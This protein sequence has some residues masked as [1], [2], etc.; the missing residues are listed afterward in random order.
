MA[1]KLLCWEIIQQTT[2]SK[3]F[4]KSVAI[5]TIPTGQLTII[6]VVLKLKNISIHPWM[7]ALNPSFV[8]FYFLREK[9][10]ETEEVEEGD[11]GY[12]FL[13]LPR[14]ISTVIFLFYPT[15][16]QAM[17]G[18]A[19]LCATQWNQD[20]HRQTCPTTHQG[21]RVCWT[22]LHAQQ[23]QALG[24]DF[25]WAYPKLPA[26]RHWGCSGPVCATL[27]ELASNLEESNTLKAFPL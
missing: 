25:M 11:S 23:A 4:T 27:A 14:L 21:P 12:H 24:S 9:Y 6:T 19:H 10:H 2:L 16:L 8:H 18:G 17:S 13:S 1:E 5:T 26:G 7:A 15:A 20:V 22:L 3:L